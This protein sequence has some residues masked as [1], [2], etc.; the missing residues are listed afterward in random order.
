[1]VLWAEDVAQGGGD[2]SMC[3]AL[4]LILNAT[5]IKYMVLT[6]NTPVKTV[7]CLIF[8]QRKV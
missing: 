3:E 4:V 6:L 7:A 2:H 8:H 1:M 5:Q